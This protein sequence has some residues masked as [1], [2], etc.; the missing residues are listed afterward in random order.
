MY[1]INIKITLLA[2]SQPCI[3]SLV[4]SMELNNMYSC[5]V[6]TQYYNNNFSLLPFSSFISLYVCPLCIPTPLIRL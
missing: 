3:H 6:Y 2:Q 1:V 5:T 4:S